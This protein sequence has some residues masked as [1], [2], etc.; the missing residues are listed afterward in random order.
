MLKKCWVLKLF[1]GVRDGARENETFQ[2]Q[3]FG[4]ISRL[5][6]GTF[7]QVRVTLGS[8]WSYFGLGAIVARFRNTFIFLI[9][10]NDLMQLM[11]NLGHF[12]ISFGL[13]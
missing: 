10:S 4:V 13:F 3:G 9:D 8:L 7:S 12:G 2:D 1:E 11:V 6:W 5:L